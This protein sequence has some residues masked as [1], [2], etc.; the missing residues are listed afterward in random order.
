[1]CPL[2]VPI[3]PSIDG[4]AFFAS[5]PFNYCSS[6][7][8]LVRTR[9]STAS[10]TRGAA[11]HFAWRE[12]E[13]AAEVV[14]D[15][16]DDDDDDEIAADA[17]SSPGLSSSSKST[18]S[19]A[20]AAAPALPAAAAAARGFDRH[21]RGRGGRDGAMSSA[22]LFP[23]A[24]PRASREKAQKEGR[25]NKIV[26]K[27]NH[28]SSLFPEKRRRGPVLSPSPEPWPRRTGTAMPQPQPH[29][30]WTCSRR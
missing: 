22:F 13:A 10:I 12:T 7:R 23:P 9:N 17:A 25:E 2:P 4:I 1:M 18:R 30:S 20:V 21:A 28:C 8:S 6:F 15:D 14:V 24:A 27:K 26:V 29:P 19:V 11:S 3:D 5:T 16:D